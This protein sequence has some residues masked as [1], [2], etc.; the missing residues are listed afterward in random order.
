MDFDQDGKNCQVSK[1]FRF[2]KMNVTTLFLQRI[3][4]DSQHFMEMISN[5]FYKC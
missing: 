2:V 5:P 1:S 3:S 4:M